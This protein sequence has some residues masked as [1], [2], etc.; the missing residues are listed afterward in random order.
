H[1]RALLRTHI[2]D[3][4]VLGT[5]MLGEREIVAIRRPRP[6]PHRRAETYATRFRAVCGDHEQAAAP[7]GEPG[8]RIRA[9]TQHATENGDSRQ[10]AATHAEESG[11]NRRLHRRFRLE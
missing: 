4:T 9:T 5:R 11:T 2:D 6:G 3:E 8:V 10:I 7:F 1:C